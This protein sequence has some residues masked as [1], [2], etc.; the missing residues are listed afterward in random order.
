MNDAIFFFFYNLAHKS[1]FFDELII[2]SADTLPYFFV[3]SALIFLLFHHEVF[4]SQNPFKEF[5]KKWKEIVLVFVSGVMAW[6]AAVFLKLLV[7]SPRPF[8]ALNDVS[9]LLPETGFAFPSQHTAFC[10]ALAFSIFLSHKKAG[11][12]FMFFALIIGIARIVAGVHFPV[13]IL[14]GFILGGVIAYFLRN[15]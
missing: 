1:S 8:M 5:K 6:C 15:V 10:T 3:L 4:P 9:A 14:G 11:Y 13:D 12:I 7:A 2:F